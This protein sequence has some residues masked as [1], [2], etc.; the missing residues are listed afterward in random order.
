MIPELKVLQSINGH[1]LG[2]TKP[3][4]TVITSRNSRFFSTKHQAAVALEEITA[5]AR[6]N[7][8]A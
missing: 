6:K 2:C 1:F 7:I 4:S 3:N 8:N 5:Y